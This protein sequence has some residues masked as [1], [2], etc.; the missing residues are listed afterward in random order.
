[1]K[2]LGAPLYAAVM[3]S[4]G[5]A[6]ML[7]EGAGVNESPLRTGGE[8]GYGAVAKDVEV[9]AVVAAAVAAD[10]ARISGT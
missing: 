8:H 6:A 5:V 4:T 7:I 3:N 10:G 1:M 2:W 9:A